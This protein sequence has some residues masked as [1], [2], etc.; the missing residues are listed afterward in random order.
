MVSSQCLTSCVFR[1][2]RG[3]NLDKFFENQKKKNYGNFFC[4]YLPES[5]RDVSE[6]VWK[7]PNQ[8]F[9]F[10]DFC[11]FGPNGQKMDPKS[12]VNRQYFENVLAEKKLKFEKNRKSGFVSPC[13]M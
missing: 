8:N 7:L 10:S 12:G 1:K 3:Q 2:S 5:I 13:A 6:T 4:Y 11:E 9:D